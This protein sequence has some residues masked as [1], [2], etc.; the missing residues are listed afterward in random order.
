MCAGMVVLIIEN[1]VCPDACP[2]ACR[3]ASF[4]IAKSVVVNKPIVKQ[5]GKAL[6]VWDPVARFEN[7]RFDV[8][9]ASQVVIDC[10]GREQRG[11]VAAVHTDL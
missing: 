9:L 2:T 8:H 11:A 6:I 7:S 10:R 3:E 4:E 1:T 5:H